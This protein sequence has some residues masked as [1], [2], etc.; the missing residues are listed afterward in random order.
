MSKKIKHYIKKHHTKVIGL[1]PDPLGWTCIT[2]PGVHE[3][4]AQNNKNEAK[5]LAHAWSFGHNN[6]PN[7]GGQIDQI[8]GQPVAW[9][10]YLFTAKF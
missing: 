8:P 3:Q 1:I 7:L 9:K 5:F 2:C 4:D 10:M 6:R